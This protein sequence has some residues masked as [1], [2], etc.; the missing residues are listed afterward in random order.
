MADTHDVQIAFHNPLSP[1][2]LAACLQL[3][4]C[5]PNFAIQEYPNDNANIE[6]TNGLRGR[7][8]VPGLPNPEKGFIPMAA[9]RISASSYRRIFEQTTR[10]TIP[11]QWLC[12]RTW[13][14]S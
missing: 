4:A 11:G 13:M 2:N 10:G 12:A 9:R 3:D 14:A 8:K 5:I 7:R 1:V 6:G